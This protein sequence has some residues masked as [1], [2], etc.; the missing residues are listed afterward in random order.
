MR[1]SLHDGNVKIYLLIF[2]DTETVISAKH[3]VLDESVSY[4]PEEEEVITDLDQ[5]ASGIDSTSVSII[6]KH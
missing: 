5:Q 4:C 1:N 6:S 3:S 2:L